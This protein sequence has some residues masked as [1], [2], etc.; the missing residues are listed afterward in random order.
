MCSCS[1]C[2]NWQNIT[3]AIFD[4]RWDRKVERSMFGVCLRE[5]KSLRI[6]S[7]C[8]QDDKTLKVDAISTL[9]A[10]SVA[11]IRATRP[12]VLDLLLLKPDHTLILLTHGLHE[13]S[14][15]PEIRLGA[16]NDAATIPIDIQP[17]PTSIHSI[18]S[19]LVVAIKNPSF[20]SITAVF[21]DGSC[22]R[23]CIDLS[24]QDD[25]T[26]RCF[27]TLAMALPTELA[28]SLRLKFLHLWSE[29]NL[30]T[31]TDTEFRCFSRAL[32][33]LFNIGCSRVTES[34]MLWQDLPQTNSH[35]EFRE[36][37]AL[38]GLQLPPLPIIYSSTKAPARK[39]HPLLG[40]VL[41]ALH[42]LAEELRV[43]RNHHRA[44]FKLV[45]VICRIARVVRPEWA[46]YW[47]RFCPDVVSEWS[48]TDFIGLLHT[49]IKRVIGS[50]ALCF[51]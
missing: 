18:Q 40:A 6:M 10:L 34:S 26:L 28:F 29:Q 23:A 50:S 39:P 33:T 14:I 15:K 3:A 1:S 37:V 49:F 8:R 35:E 4:L 48:P 43:T 46:D 22:A 11:P 17:S 30:S 44:L 7:I 20:S 36:D 25:L 51:S 32:Y 21:S 13:I 9:R 12:N 27:Q 24:P 47:T 2:A 19:V 5:T 45:P 41:N 16:E 38:Q 42:S 31:A